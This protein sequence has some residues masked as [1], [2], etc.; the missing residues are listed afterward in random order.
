MCYFDKKRRKGLES[1]SRHIFDLEAG[2]LF[3]PK[4][5]FCLT[6]N[7]KIEFFENISKHSLIYRDNGDVAQ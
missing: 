2:F 5:D 6:Q 7:S 3:Y 4:F 1:D